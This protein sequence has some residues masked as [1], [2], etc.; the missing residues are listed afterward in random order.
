MSHITITPTLNQ[1]HEFL[2]DFNNLSSEDQQFFNI[3]TFDVIEY[4]IYG[5]MTGALYGLLKKND[6]N[7]EKSS[8]SPNKD[9]YLGGHIKISCDKP[10]TS[11]IINKV[12]DI[13]KKTDLSQCYGMEIYSV[14][15]HNRRFETFKTFI[16]SYIN[17]VNHN[18][19]KPGGVGYYE[20]LDDFNDKIKNEL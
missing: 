8:S 10:I 5:T 12:N 15:E 16:N 13:I 3:E 19:Y 18:L 9:F 4:Y 6:N 14:M 1:L 11:E 7:L 20:L 17:Y 2:K